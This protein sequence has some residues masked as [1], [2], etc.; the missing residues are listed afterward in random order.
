VHANTHC[1][2]TLSESYCVTDEDSSDSSSS[3]DYQQQQQHQQQQQQLSRGRSEGGWWAGWKGR[4]TE[5][6]NSGVLPTTRHLFGG[7]WQHVLTCSKVIT[8]GSVLGLAG[9][10]NAVLSVMLAGRALCTIAVT[11]T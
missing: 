4:V 2:H 5:G 10:A 6:G 9:S 7:V 8:L 1:H 11:E 3:D